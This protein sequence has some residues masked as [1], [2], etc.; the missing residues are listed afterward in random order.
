[1]DNEDIWIIRYTR[2]YNIS[3]VKYAIDRI[4]SILLQTVNGSLNF[5]HEVKI[6]KYLES[7]IYDSVPRKFQFECSFGITK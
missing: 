5:L 3:R 7:K 1:M 2:K 4:K 6:S